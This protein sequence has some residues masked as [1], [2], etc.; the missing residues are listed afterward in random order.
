MGL[1]LVFKFSP[2]V[3]ST[4]DQ[5]DTPDLSVSILGTT[6]GARGWIRT[7]AQLNCI[8]DASPAD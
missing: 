1:A 4:M 5:T 3:E 7:F 2:F 8:A 6:E